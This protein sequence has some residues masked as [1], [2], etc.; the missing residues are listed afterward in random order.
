[1]SQRIEELIEAFDRYDGRYKRQQMEDAVA[2]K[3]EIT[4]RLIL[5]L[6]ELAADPAKYA[7]EG[8]YANTY[9]VALLAH[10]KE[11]AAHLPIIRAFSSPREQLDQLWGDMVTETLPTLLFQTCDGSL[12]TIKEMVLDRELRVNVRNAATTALTYAVARGVANREEIIGFLSALF[13]GEEADKDEDFWGEL[14][15]SI[16][17]MYPEGAMDVIRKAFADGL[18][19]DDYVGLDEIEVD[20]LKEKEVVLDALR[21]HVDRRVPTDV[22]DY[23]SWFASFEENEHPARLGGSLPKAQKKKKNAN[24]IKN[25]MAKKSKRKNKK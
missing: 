10:F 18:I 20:L 3:E 12:D 11:P 6:E 22:H 7:R 1:M 19:R 16:A 24:R 25:K 14:A 5:L 23:L 17:D 8:H 13:T 21:L 4:P 2:L 15:C 9:A